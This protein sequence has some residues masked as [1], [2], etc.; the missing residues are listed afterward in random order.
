V[1]EG[2][3][4]TGQAR[5]QSH[6]LAAIPRTSTGSYMAT[7]SLSALER[8][9]RWQSGGERR[10]AVDDPVAI[11]VPGTRVSMHNSGGDPLISLR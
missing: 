1:H 3:S 5:I 9:R 2:L 10:L 6:D 4:T 7:A 8:Q 11:L